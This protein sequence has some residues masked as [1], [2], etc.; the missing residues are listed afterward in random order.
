MQRKTSLSRRSFIA[1]TGITGT[2]FIIGLNNACNNAPKVAN[3]SEVKQWFEF[4]PY[5]HIADN[6]IVTVFTTKPEIGQGVYQS[7]PAIVCEELEVPLET[8][9]I[10]Q[11][12]GE[13]KYGPMQFAGGSYSVRGSY[14]DLRKVGASAK[15]M[16][17]KAASQE[18]KVP[19][20]ECYAENG[21]VI[22]KPSGKK[23]GYGP[24]AAASKLPVPENPN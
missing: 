23:L 11:T 12:G 17:I 5:V 6:G 21:E 2:G 3:L 18:W 16:L 14:H 24:L 19:E 10:K 4:T 13:K 20:S 7:I 22:H 8:V 15:E 9:I 1:I